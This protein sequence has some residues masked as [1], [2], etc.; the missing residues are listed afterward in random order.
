ME[1][2][3]EPTVPV[4]LAAAAAVFGQLRQ[5][6]G[7]NA[8][9]PIVGPDDLG[10]FPHV[11]AAPRPVVLDANRLYQDLRPACRNDRR[12]VLVSAANAGAIRLFCARHVV[13]EF[14]E[15]ADEWADKAE[16]DRGVFMRRW[17]SEYAPLLRVVD[18]PAVLLTPAEAS[19]VDLLEFGPEEFRDADDVPTARLALVLGAFFLSRDKKPVKAVHGHDVDLVEREAWLDVL[20]A[21]GDVHV[22]QE[23]KRGDEL[24]FGV[25]GQ[26]AFL[27]VGKLW[28]FSPPA[29]LL[30]CGVMYW[31]WRRAPAG[32]RGSVANVATGF[33]VHWSQAAELA[34][35]AG[36]RFTAASVPAPAWSG[37][38][39]QVGSAAALERACL[40]VLARAGG[41]A[42][43]AEVTEQVRELGVPASEARV[44]SVLRADAVKVA[45]GRFQ[46]GV[47][48]AS[49]AS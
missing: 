25:A 42:S 13:D 18:V 40:F 36:S 1:N 12:T 9:A 7:R 35:R 21:G 43:A 46:L 28:R 32:F 17:A 37:L 29:A 3:G 26:L 4:P 41:S 11:G 39:G 15:H 8:A 20:R 6:H 48:A 22:L 19:R 30:T 10:R 38:A 47:P 45:R 2:P 23:M 16:I 27:G 44:R 33:T 49:L 24:A 14:Y 5:T 31:A 34:Q